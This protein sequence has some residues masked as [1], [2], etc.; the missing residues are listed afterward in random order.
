[1]DQEVVRHIVSWRW[2]PGVSWNFSGLRSFRVGVQGKEILEPWPNRSG[3]HPR[4]QH[5]LFKSAAAYR[6]N[7]YCEDQSESQDPS[8]NAGRVPSRSTL[9]VARTHRV[10]ILSILEE[11]Q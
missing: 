9:A 10:T 1:M 4:N 3:D 7:E 5:L 2:R 8:R 6:L 11:E